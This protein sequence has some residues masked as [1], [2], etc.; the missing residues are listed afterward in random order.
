MPINK[1]GIRQEVYVKATD[2]DA[3]VAVESVLGVLGFIDYFEVRGGDWC[4]V[5]FLLSSGI[6][7][8]P[9]PHRAPFLFI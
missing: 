4:C 7:T 3:I 1:K 9:P 8:P 6:T 5:S 2:F